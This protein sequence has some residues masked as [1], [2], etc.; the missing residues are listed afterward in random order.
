MDEIEQL[1]LLDVI[2]K[3]SL[4]TLQDLFSD[5]T[6]LSVVAFDSTGELTK[7]SNM[8]ETSTSFAKRMPDEHT[9]YINKA[10]DD[11]KS[12]GHAVV[13]DTFLGF[14]E[15][16]VPI[17]LK[18]RVLGFF[19]GGQVLTEKPSE[20]GIRK[21]STAHGF[22]AAAI[23][24]MLSKLEI[25][26]ESRL[27]AAAELL[28]NMVND[29]LENSYQHMQAA[30]R[31]RVARESLDDGFV[32][33]NSIRGKINTAVEY[34]S[35][36]ERG[37]ERIKDA[38]SDSTRAVDSTDNIVKTIENSSTQLTLIG[39]NASIEAKRAGAAGAGFNVI[40]QEVRTLAEK[41]TKQAGEIEHTLNGIKKSMGD[42]NNQIRGLYSDIEK[43]VDSINDLSIAVIDSE[44]K[45]DNGAK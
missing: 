38:V 30:E 35:N 3:T 21:F 39:F 14:T 23:L 37:C 18:G 43:I 44:N 11:A 45:E 27:N 4:Q 17:S 41:N 36:V 29:E 40:A 24:E 8:T 26:P 13:Y 22:N 31:G 20:Q 7:W 10:C 12:R 16:V 28:M 2:S 33:D 32:D 6:G 15:F 42:I 19:N 25:V 9:K 34:V 1:K 5:A